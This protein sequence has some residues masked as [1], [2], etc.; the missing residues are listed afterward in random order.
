MSKMEQIIKGLEQKGIL[1]KMIRT[2]FKSHEQEMSEQPRR[3]CSTR[4]YLESIMEKDDIKSN[5]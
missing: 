5:D 1:A 3:K 2:I 4:Q